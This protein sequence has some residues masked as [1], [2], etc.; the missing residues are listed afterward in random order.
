MSLSRRLRQPSLFFGLLCVLLLCGAALYNLWFIDS[1]NGT[2]FGRSQTVWMVAGL[3]GGGIV[4]G[5]DMGFLRRV[6]GTVYQAL[7]LLLVA[8]LLFGREINHSKRWIELGPMN[9]QP[10][11]FMKLAVVMVM[12]DYF[13]RQRAQEAWTLRRLG[14]PLLLLG[15]PVVLIN[16]EPDLGT[17]LCVALIAGSM[18]LYEGVNRRTLL[19]GLFLVV[20]GVPLAWRSGV[21][22]G[23]QKGRVQAWMALDEAALQ[24]RRRAPA[25]QP[26][27]ALWA[28][29]SGRWTGRDADDARRS[30]LRHLP[31]LYTDFALASWAE[32][33][34]LLGTMGLF[35][36]FAGM[37]WWALYLADCAAE[38]FD[39]LV[40][41][42]VAALI[43]WQFFINAGMVIGLL[44]VVGMTLPLMSYGG[45]SVLTVL[46]GIGLLVNIALRRRARG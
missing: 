19:A 33:F 24:E 41:V 17:S 43:F 44:P 2:S 13:D 28:V 30:V 27:Q 46:I 12:A 22:H 20:L 38:R 40:A 42:G 16:R 45:S 21:I 11:E 23:Y 36:L 31:F 6:S 34:G 4:A 26:E 7:V 10:S 5:M 3:V 9:L 35:G 14:W 39:A 15:V 1:L 32:L 8:V 25:S 18:I 29:G 37:L